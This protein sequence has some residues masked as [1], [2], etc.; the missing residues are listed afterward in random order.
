MPDKI[1]QIKVIFATMYTIKCN[2]IKVKAIDIQPTSTNIKNQIE[3]YS[4]LH[5]Y[6]KVLPPPG[7]R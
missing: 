3:I 7:M 5:K 2:H 1:D 6:P 4:I